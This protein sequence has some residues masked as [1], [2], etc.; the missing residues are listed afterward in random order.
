M[1]T[2]F[3]LS[4]ADSNSGGPTR[5]SPLEAS[6]TTAPSP[7]SREGIASPEVS[8]NKVSVSA[9]AGTP[10][11]GPLLLSA[12]DGHVPNGDHQIGL[13][14]TT[15][16]Q[17]GAHVG[18]VVQ[19]TVP[20]PS[21]GRRTVPFRVVS[22]ISF[23]VVADAVSLG[24]G[25]AFTIAGYQAAVCP[26]GPRQA[27]A[28]RRWREPLSARSSSASC[29]AR[30]GRLQSANTSTGHRE[31]RAP[32]HPDIAHQ[33]RRGSQLPAHLWCDVGSVRRRD[34]P[35]S[36][37]GQRL[38]P[39][40]GSRALE[41]ARLRERPGRLRRGLASVDLGSRRD[42]HR[43]AAR[44]WWSV[45]PCGGRSPTTSALFPISVVP[46]LAHRRTDSGV[47]VVANLI[48]VTPALLATRSKPGEL[49]RT[50]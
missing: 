49:L 4:S 32:D 13:G 40:T 24:N 34:A 37:R 25:A 10:I 3:Q 14:A 44:A 6:S 45:R 1:A 18:S 31:R 35:T 22:Q 36:P 12:V 11:R 23:P 26:S 2:P 7:G 38:S 43:C 48:A 50:A 42:R 46:D 16:R 8:V 28:D 21:G 9:V 47:I 29:P 15:M 41:G 19:V 30:G 20:L 39:P 5:P 27:R 17:A 33:L